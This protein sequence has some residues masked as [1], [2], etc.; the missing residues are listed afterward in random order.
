MYIEIPTYLLTLVALC[1]K[2]FSNLD[3][4]L[5][6]KGPKWPFNCRLIHFYEK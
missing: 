4:T 2:S 5:L 3:V 6:N 1:T